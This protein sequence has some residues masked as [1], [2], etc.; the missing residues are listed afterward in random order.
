MI[1]FITQLRMFDSPLWHYHIIVA[2]DIAKKFIVAE[3]KRVIC[4]IDQITW[5]AALMKS[6]EYW[7]ILVNN[8][9]RNK[10]GLKEGD[11]VVVNLVK[12]LSEYG[13]EMPEELG[14]LLEQD[15]EAN[16]YFMNLT[17]GKRRSLIYLVQKVKNTHSRLS[18]SLAIAHHLKDVKGN[19]DFKLLNE[20]IKAY[21]KK[22]I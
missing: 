6:Q 20:T 8:E 22:S 18:K 9:N 1:K 12:D 15:E 16:R 14:V 4:T 11:E 2:E 7:F 10:L 13:F 17:M 21:N 19:L 3:N 5:P